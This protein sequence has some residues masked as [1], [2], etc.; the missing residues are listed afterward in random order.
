MKDYYDILDVPIT[1]TSEQIKIRY[2]QLVR[3]YHPDR[4]SNPLDRLYAERKLKEVNEAYRVLVTETD[5]PPTTFT[6]RGRLPIPTVEPEILDFGVLYPGDRQ[7][8]RFQVDNS[9]GSATAVTFACSETNSWFRITNGKR[10]ELAKPLP[11]EFEVVADINSTLPAQHYSGWIE[12]NM[13]GVKKRVQILA[14]VENLKSSSARL[15]YRHWLTLGCISILLLII[16]T[17]LSFLSYQ[18][19]LWAWPFHHPLSAVE[20]GADQANAGALLDRGS[21]PP[22][23]TIGSLDH[24]QADA[25]TPRPT[26]IYARVA[27]SSPAREVDLRPVS[28]EVVGAITTMHTQS[29]TL[30][31]TGAVA[32]SI[33]PTNT[34][35]SAPTVTPLPTDT[36]TVA[37]SPTNTPV[38]TATPTAIA[39]DTPEP[40]PTATNTNTPLPTTTPSATPSPTRTPFPTA[41]QTVTPSPWP[42]ATLTKPPTPTP[43][44]A[45]TEQKLATATGITVAIPS[46]HQVNA[47]YGW[48][49]DSPSLMLL[50]AGSVWPALGRSIDNA[51]VQIRLPDGRL[52][53]LFTQVIG[54]DLAQIQKLPV[55]MAPPWP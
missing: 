42:T 51:W 54:A 4:F 50:P 48:D 30:P 17:Q 21:A 11:L 29:T 52:A 46:E 12:I 15:S 9:G 19:A 38:P 20:A 43:L 53:W 10:V 32:A 33:S 28:I 7:A 49:I 31:A 14:Q 35:T 27:I 2:K 8:L 26:P 41:T 36:S 13:D 22:T 6:A 39:T 55:V 40:S 23:P 16:T 44:K 25:P 37:P 24:I 34:A 1:A 5:E 3:I 45:P 47:R 18:R